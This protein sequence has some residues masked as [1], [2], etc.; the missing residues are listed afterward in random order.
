MTKKALG[1]GLGV[2]L[3]DDYGI[4]KDERYAEVDIEDVLPNPLQPRLKFDSKSI[5][6]LAQ[7][8]KESGVI[9]P[10]LVVPDG[11]N[12]KIII[13]ERRWR[14]AQK[15][16]LKKIPVLIRSIP[17]ER[18]LEISL[19]ENLHRE[20]LNPLEV[21]LVYKRMI[22]ELHYSQ[23]DIADRIGMDR[24]SVTNYLRLL[25]LPRVV[26]DYLA[27][28]KISMGHARALVSVEN[29]EFQISLAQEIVRKNLT[30]RDI[31]RIIS[32]LKKQ[33]LWVPREKKADPD[34]HAVEEE[35]IK[36][37]GT[38]VS[39]LGSRKKGTIRI[40][41][42]SLDDLNRIYEKIKGVTS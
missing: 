29:P 28:D 5:D 33:P 36:L 15:A 42:F 3:P 8:I 16:G 35:L 1:K 17:K 40:F 10:I 21:G 20:N 9:Q 27:E 7:S 31:E 24:T 22:E 32:R 39:I 11:E 14:A 23:Q 26:Q 37:L 18:H 12:Y 19:I 2:F 41:Y 30:V 4:L 38:K 25:T 13:G 34:L 6:E